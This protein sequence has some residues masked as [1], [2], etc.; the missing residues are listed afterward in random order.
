MKQAPNGWITENNRLTLQLT[1]KDF[2][3]AIALLNAIGDIAE[4]QNHHPDITIKDYNQ[5][6]ISITTH[7]K[8]GLTDNDYELAQAITALIGQNDQKAEIELDESKQ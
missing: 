8:G 2:K 3:H 5:L 6:S 4:K 7:D 1:C